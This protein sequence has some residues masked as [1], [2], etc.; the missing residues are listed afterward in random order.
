MSFTR[1]RAGATAAAVAIVGLV[2]GC[3]GGGGGGADQTLDPANPVEI[4]VGTLPAGDYAPLYIAEQEGYFEEAGL[5]VTIEIIAG[6]A[7]GMTQ[8]V[9][10]DLDF[11]AA[12]W[13]NVLLANSQGFDIQVVREGTNAG[14]E[15]INGMLVQSD[16]PINE[17]EDLRGETVSVNT[18]GSATE[19]QLR[20]CLATY[21][22]EPS[23]Y[24]LVEVAFPDAAA[25]V[26]QGRI[27][28]GFV[29]EPFI[30]IGAE[31]GLE[32]LFYPS[33][34]ND[35]QSTLPLINWNTSMSFAD[36][37]PAVV[38]AFKD[39]MD[40]ATD[41]AIEDPQVVIDILPTFTTLTPELAETIV[42][43]SYTADGTPDLE[44]AQ[45]VMDE[46]VKYEL[47]DA[48]LDDIAQYAWT[49]PGEGE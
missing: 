25:A 2:A 13:T 26:S 27:A 15:G 5:D 6:G 33:T 42:H 38:A 36:E 10:G 14:K 21:G 30:T 4:T 1:K 37:N 32:P 45:T 34:C 3:S 24:E 28:A 41:L 12:T 17:P 11:S 48:P 46:M 31:E 44:G 16:G 18:L 23:D 29:P 8:L 47:L 40:R 49:P 39:A 22:L 43:A 20:D 9:S 35:L 19:I 7:V